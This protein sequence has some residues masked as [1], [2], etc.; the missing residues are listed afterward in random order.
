M[1]RGKAGISLWPQRMTNVG[2]AESGTESSRWRDVPKGT[3]KTE[4]IRHGQQQTVICF[5]LPGT[6]QGRMGVLGNESV[7]ENQA[8]R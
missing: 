4:A 5:T 6:L 8:P 1:E 2:D 3:I 7:K